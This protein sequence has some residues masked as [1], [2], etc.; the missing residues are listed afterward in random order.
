MAY[1]RGDY[2][3]AH[4]QFL[5]FAERGDV[6]AQFY[7]GRMYREGEGVP[8][9]YAE[10]A[11]WYRLAAYQDW[12]RLKT[13]SVSCMR[14]VKE[15]VGIWNW[16]ICGSTFRLAPFGFREGNKQGA[17]TICE[18]SYC[19]LDQQDDLEEGQPNGK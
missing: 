11:N 3:T 7:L 12:S 5:S 9:D 2:A 15:S 13:I 16:H 17:R 14:M 4:Y 10:A 6:H 1:D 8:Q 18:P 19:A